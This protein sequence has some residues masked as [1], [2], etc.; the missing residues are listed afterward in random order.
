MSDL[1]NRHADEEREVSSEEESN[2]NNNKDNGV[3]SSEANDDDDYS[4]DNYVSSQVQLLWNLVQL[5]EPN[6]ANR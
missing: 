6:D 3:L 1:S 4:Q 5:T 2:S